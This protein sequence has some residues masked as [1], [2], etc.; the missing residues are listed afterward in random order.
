MDR[1]M[2]N[3]KRKRPLKG[4]E[5]FTLIELMVVV[6]IMGL[7]VALVA[8][9]F[10]GKVEQSKMKTAQ[11]QIELFGSAL[12]MFRLDVGAYPSASYGMEALRTRPQAARRS[13]PR[14][15]RRSPSTKWGT[16]VQPAP[17]L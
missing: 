8:P 12:D 6:V 2:K 15:W 11:A 1:S 4:A 14:A 10:F 13:A 16:P 5:G 9:R 17:S 7:L 3:G